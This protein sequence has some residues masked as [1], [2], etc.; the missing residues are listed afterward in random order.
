MRYRGQGHEIRVPLPDVPFGSGA[1]PA[2]R[3]AFERAYAATYGHTAPGVPVDI[4]SWRVAAHGPKPPLRLPPGVSDAA[5]SDASAAL[6]G[7]RPVYIPERQDFVEVPVF[8]RYRLA[9]GHEFDGPAV[10]EERE[11]T[12][13]VGPGARG[14]IDA[15]RNLVMENMER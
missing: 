2:F 13:I 14:R 10:V 1:E 5:S 15:W 6:K 4:V 8:D 11:S 3:D 9:A 7:R 12:V